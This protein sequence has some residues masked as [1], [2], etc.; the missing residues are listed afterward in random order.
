MGKCITNTPSLLMAAHG[1]VAKITARPG[2]FPA[3]APYA[4]ALHW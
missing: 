3:Q 4:L 2:S 1:D